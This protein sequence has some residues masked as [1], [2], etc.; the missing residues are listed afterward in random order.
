MSAPFS[1]SGRREV[2][3]LMKKYHICGSKI[4]NEDLKRYIPGGV[5]SSF[6]KPQYRDYPLAIDYGKGSKLYDVD[7]LS[8]AE[9]S[10]FAHSVIANQQRLLENSY[11]PMTEEQI[12][13]IYESLYD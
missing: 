4:L 9:L 10:E 6:H 3:D 7:G 12:L 2:D 1:V 8:R 11:I 13:S 5:S